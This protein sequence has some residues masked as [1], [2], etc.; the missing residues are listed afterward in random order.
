MLRFELSCRDTPFDQ[1]LSRSG[2]ARR[3]RDTALTRWGHRLDLS[4][5]HAGLTSRLGTPLYVSSH[6]LCTARRT[7]SV[8]N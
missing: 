5:T 8:K 6:I 1:A 7:H 4:F 3:V 2:L